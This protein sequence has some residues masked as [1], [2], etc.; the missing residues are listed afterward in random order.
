MHVPATGP[1]TIGGGHM[2]MPSALRICGGGHFGS[3]THIPRS[4]TVP[5][6]HLHGPGTSGGGQIC[7][8]H[9]RSCITVPGGQM[10]VSAGPRTS[11][12]GHSRRCGTQVSVIGSRTSGGRHEICRF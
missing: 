12:G 11:G 9:L 6:G 4:C 3:G 10:Q 8:T 5:S 7:G 2:Q 1:G